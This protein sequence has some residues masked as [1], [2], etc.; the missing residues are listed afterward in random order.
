[1]LPCLGVS[2]A[3]ALDSISNASKAV[4][5]R[6]RGKDLGPFFSQVLPPYSRGSACSKA[7]YR[8]GKT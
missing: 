7:C 2:R 6:G 3:F 5:I 8:A 1:M 4:S